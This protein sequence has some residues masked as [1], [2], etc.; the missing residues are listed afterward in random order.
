MIYEIPKK[1]IQLMSGFDFT[2]LLSLLIFST[3][4]F[5]LLLEILVMD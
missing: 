5:F 3:S 4:V 2:A 1:E